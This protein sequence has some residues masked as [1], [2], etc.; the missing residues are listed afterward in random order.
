[1]SSE[2]RNPRG[3]DPR[4]I[5]DGL[6]AFRQAGSIFVFAG[7]QLDSPTTLQNTEVTNFLYAKPPSHRKK[8]DPI[9]EGLREWQARQNVQR[10]AH[11]IDMTATNLSK[12][13]LVHFITGEELE[14]NVAHAISQELM[15][16][17][18][19]IINTQTPEEAVV[20]FYEEQTL[21]Q[22]INTLRRGK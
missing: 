18:N 10:P 11:T 4:T 22:Q 5:H 12:E 9:D 21:Q 14:T 16:L 1:M 13:A 2:F 17:H 3:I 19:K 8:R 6:E 15:S 20:C 7:S